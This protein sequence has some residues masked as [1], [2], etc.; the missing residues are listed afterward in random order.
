VGSSLDC[1]AEAPLETSDPGPCELRYETYG[2]IDHHDGFAP[3]LPAESR[4]RHS[5]WQAPRRRIYQAMLRTGQTCRRV[6][7]FADCGSALWLM[8]DGQTLSLSCN[9]CHDRLCLPCQRDRQHAV[10]EGVVL[11]MLDCG[12]T[13]RFVTLTLKHSDAPLSVQLTRLV[14]SFKALRK[15]PAVAAAIGGG[16]WFIE[17]K[18]SKDKARW[19]P[20]LHVIVEGEFINAKTLSKT[21]YEVTGDSYITDIRSI[22]GVVDRARYVT[23]YATKPLHNEVT[24]Q[25]AKLD[26]FVTAIKGRRLYQCFGTWS[27]AVKREKPSGHKL[28]RV[29]ALTTLHRDALDGDVQ[30][31]VL[32]HQAHARWPQLRRTF[33]IPPEWHAP[34]PLDP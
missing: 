17:V 20:H 15:H 8:R 3:S 11:R 31:L 9:R 1:L 18:L 33:P 29:A 28:T 6:Q 23:K 7:H 14:D 2:A 16:A 5:A 13:C 19:H 4:F 22:G 32:L 27:K 26:E 12:G 10:V 34:P 25:P 21:W 24:L 30:S